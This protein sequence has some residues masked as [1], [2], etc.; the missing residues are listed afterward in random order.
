MTNRHQSQHNLRVFVSLGHRSDAVKHSKLK[1]K[2]A[3]TGMAARNALTFYST[4]LL[5][6]KPARL[7]T[8][9]QL[10]NNFAVSQVQS[11]I[12]FNFYAW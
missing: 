6:I 8:E 1:L 3:P 5:S 9:F 4:K 10:C 2:I 7:K 12:I 11:T